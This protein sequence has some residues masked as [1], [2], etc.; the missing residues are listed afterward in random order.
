MEKPPY[1]DVP[2]PMEHHGVA[3]QPE[4]R[5]S[6]E[7]IIIGG[8]LAGLSA[9]IYLGRALRDVLIIDAGESL[10]LWEPEVQNYLGFESIDGRDLLRRGREQALCYGADILHEEVERVWKEGERFRIKAKKTSFDAG[11]LLLTTGVYHLPPKIP[12][13]DDCVGKSIFFCKDCDGYRVQGKRVII[14]GHN[15]SA[16]QY[17]LGIMAFTECVMLLTNGEVP[18]W[19]KEHERWLRTYEIPIYNGKIHQV[20]HDNGCIASVTLADG[21]NLAA[22]C[23]FTT[24]GDVCHN[25]LAQQLGAELDNDGQVM[26]DADQRTNVFGLYSAGCVTPANCQMIIAA[27]DGALAAQ[28]INTDLFHEALSNGSLLEHRHGQIARGRTEPLLLF[29][30]DRSISDRA[31]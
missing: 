28:T 7:V 13:V 22:D 31:C 25:S 9:A 3:D 19:D 29:R 15:N 5:R 23:L 2:K 10:A 21:R 6:R 30:T 1:S 18:S 12:S 20:E 27:G 17:A 26:V 14:A 4:I 16:V 11:R 24:R 8:G